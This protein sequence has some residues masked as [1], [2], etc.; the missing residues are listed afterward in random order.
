MSQPIKTMV[1]GSYPQPDWLVDKE[2]LGRKRVP[3]VLVPEVW[4]IP[5]EHLGMA[6]DD[7][8]RLAVRDM[9]S[10]GVDVISDGE[11]RRESYFNQFAN[12]MEGLDLDNP[13]Q[14][15][16]RM[17]M[18]TPVPRVVAPLARR[19]SILAHDVRVLLESAQRTPKMSMPGPFTLSVLAANEH[20]PDQASLA[21]AY[22]DII[23]AEIRALRALGIGWIQLDEPYLQAR[24]DEARGYAIEAINR[25]LLDI[26]PPTV[27]H[28]CFG[29]AAVI[30]NKPSGYYFLP[31]LERTTAS[32]LSIEAAQP[33]IELDVLRKLP[34]KTVALG[35]LNLGL[36]QPDSSERITVRLRDALSHIDRHRLMAAPDCG[37]KYIPLELARAKLRAMCAGAA[38]V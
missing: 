29:Y 24:P 36:D 4:R 19:K 9:E 21:M 17:G 31:E 2:L 8:T 25:A 28:I 7:A 22:A 38:T 1:V 10:C 32:H 35:V 14:T 33:N 12:A 15:I 11:M 26:E 20:Y 5:T 3:R 27:V 37:M 13:G 18:N 23:N 34:S 16:D 6:Q 30:E